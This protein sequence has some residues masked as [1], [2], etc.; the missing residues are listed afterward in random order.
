MTSADGLG[1]SCSATRTTDARSS[2]RPKLTKT[3]TIEISTTGYNGHSESSTTT[4]TATRPA[5]PQPQQRRGQLHHNHNRTRPAPDE[6]GS[7]RVGFVVEI[8]GQSGPTCCLRRPPPEPRIVG[9][10]QCWDW[11]ARCRSVYCEWVK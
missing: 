11:S 9:Y 2:S 7:S 3:A 4:T 10:F 8:Q 6:R 5:P 1:R